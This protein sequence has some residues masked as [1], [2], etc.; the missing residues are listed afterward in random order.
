MPSVLR[1]LDQANHNEEFSATISAS[2][3]DWGITVRF[4]AAAHLVRAW[5]RGRRA[6]DSLLRSHVDIEGE[7]LKFRF[8][9][10]A[11]RA[12]RKLSDLS[13]E[14]RYDC[15]L[16]TDLQSDVAEAQ[17]LLDEIRAYVT[18]EIGRNLPP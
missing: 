10:G 4:Y 17:H 18:P 1:H 5:L 11:H 12:Y 7:L 2:Y 16:P 14:A 9:R 15:I 3:A 6:P 8:D 13:R